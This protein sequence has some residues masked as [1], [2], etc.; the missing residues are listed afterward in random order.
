VIEDK[1][2]LNLEDQR[3]NELTLLAHKECSIQHA[4]DPHQ[5]RGL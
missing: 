5:L 1:Q 4:M 2:S 3:Q